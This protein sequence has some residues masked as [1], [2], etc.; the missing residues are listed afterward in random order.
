[1]KYRIKLADGTTQLIQ[2]TTDLYKSWKVWK[3]QFADGKAAMLFKS[4][5]AWLQR[6]EDILDNYLLT[7][8]GK[9]IDEVILGK[10]RL[11]L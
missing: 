11:A 6:N 4:G 2:I 7:T 1:M 8:I 3:V 9:C 5:N 10:N